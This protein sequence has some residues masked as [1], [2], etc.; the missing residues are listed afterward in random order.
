MGGTSFSVM[1]LAF[2]VRSAPPH[3]RGVVVSG[4]LT[5]GKKT[6]LLGK[7]IYPGTAPGGCSS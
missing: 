7:A 1:L 2:I 5:Q 4:Y 3:L 6:S